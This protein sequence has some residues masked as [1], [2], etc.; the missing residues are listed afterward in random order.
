MVPTHLKMLACAAAASVL[1]ACV[2]YDEDPELR[3]YWEFI[4]AASC[5]QAGVS[6]ILIQIDGPTGFE[7]FGFVPCTLGFADIPDDFPSAG[8]LESGDYFV[9]VLG[10]PPGEGGA[11]WLAEG[12]I[13]L[14]GG[15]NEFTFGLAPF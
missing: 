4:G 6:D 2:I 14:H 1:P 5:E 11:T 15:F 8:D 12:G 7:E 9:T 10:F 13:D 3:I